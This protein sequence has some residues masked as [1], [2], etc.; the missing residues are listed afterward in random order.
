M[1]RIGIVAFRFWLALYAQSNSTSTRNR[2]KQVCRQEQLLL[3]ARVSTFE[4][5][6]SSSMQKVQAPPVLQNAEPTTDGGH[7]LHYNTL[8]IL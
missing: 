1:R 6:L 8:L 4:N 3:T 7:E 2:R 5:S